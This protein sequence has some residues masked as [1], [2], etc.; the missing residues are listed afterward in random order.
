[1]SEDNNEIPCYIPKDKRKIP[2]KRNQSSFAPPP[3]REL[4][5]VEFDCK[6]NKEELEQIKEHYRG[7]NK[8]SNTIIKPSEKFK[9]MK[10]NDLL[11]TKEEEDTTTDPNDLYN[12]PIDFQPLLGRGNC[13]GLDRVVNPNKINQEKG[14]SYNGLNTINKIKTKPLNQMNENDWRIIRE[15]LN[16][17]VN[18]NEVIKPLRKW[19]DMNVC[20]DLLLLIKN[21]YENPTP[22]QCASIPIA[23]K[24]RDLIALAETGTGKTF[25]YLIPLIQFVLKLPKLTEET[26]ASGPYALVLAP[27]RELAL[28]IQKETLKLATPFGLRVCCCIGGEPMQPQIEELSNG[29][30]I[31][32]AAPGRLKDLL[33]QSYLVLGQCYFVVLDEADKMIDLGLDVQ[34]RYIFSELPSVKDGSTEEIISMEKE[35]ASGNPSTRTTLMYS[36]TMPSTLEKITNEYLRRPITISIGKTGN[37]AENVKQNILWVEDNMKKRKLIQVIKSSSPPTI[38]FVNQQKTV[39]EICL[40]LE[41]EKINCIGIH[42]GKRQIERT[43][44]LDGFK[45]KKYSVM[46]ATNILSRGIDIESVANVINYEMP[47][48]IEEYTHRVGRTGRAGKGGNAI[49]FINENDGKEVLNQLRQILVQSRNSIPKELDSFLKKNEIIY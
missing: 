22:I 7:N 29:A 5:P 43:D 41:K 30:E 40:L 25:A 3:K 37:V 14:E 16:I 21:I 8:E 42:G 12:N 35:N 4:L 49:T 34:V 45:R 28:Q 9:V 1:M 19:D 44:A 23:L 18:N 10:I 47:Q 36:A 11:M 6:L 32:V 33:N 20:D 15:N 48:K 2:E 27:T 13:G 17:F 46:V 38:V 31:V 39:E 26:S 24:M